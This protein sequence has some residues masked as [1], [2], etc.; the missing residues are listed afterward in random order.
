[1]K[2]IINLDSYNS[3][4]K[5]LN[6]FKGLFTEMYSANY[7]ALIDTLTGFDHKLEITFEYYDEFTDLG[8]LAEVME[9]IENENPRIIIYWAK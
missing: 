1:M 7:D 8:N 4:E 6:H 5:L 2:L 3:K 9:I